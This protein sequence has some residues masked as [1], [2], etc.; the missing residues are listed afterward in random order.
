MTI[1]LHEITFPVF[2]IRSFEKIFREEDKI[3]VVGSKL[4]EPLILDDLSYDLPFPRRRLQIP[5]NV[6]YKINKSY[7]NISQFLRAKTYK[8]TFVDSVGL[9][10]NYTKTKSTKLTYHRLI[11]VL[12]IEDHGNALIIQDV[13]MPL[14]VS[15]LEPIKKYVGLLDYLGGY[16]VYEYSDERKKDTWR[17]I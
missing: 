17:M 14:M 3:F 12:P 8:R 9:I 2:A 16:I 11:K 4:R 7:M 10:F 15:A 6:K 1:A 13:S 5:E